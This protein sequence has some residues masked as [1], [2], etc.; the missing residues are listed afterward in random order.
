VKS[1]APTEYRSHRTP[2]SLSLSFGRS[3]S[4]SAPLALAHGSVLSASS[5]SASSSSSRSFS[6]FSGSGFFCMYC[7][8]L[9][10]RKHE[11]QSYVCRNF[12][13]LFIP[14]SRNVV[15]LTGS[16]RGS[17]S[18]VGCNAARD[19]RRTLAILVGIPKTIAGSRCLTAGSAVFWSTT[20][21]IREF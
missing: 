2:Q 18:R 7:Q 6:V 12:C 3:S 14:A 4:S 5:S 1:R 21:T 20:S 13:E 10:I 16:S 9:C 8:Y 15:G 17:G 11:E 19:G